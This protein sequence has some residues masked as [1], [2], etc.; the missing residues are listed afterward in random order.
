[1]SLVPNSKYLRHM[2]F[3]DTMKVPVEISSR[4]YEIDWLFCLLDRYLLE[5][6]LHKEWDHMVVWFISYKGK[7]IIENIG[8]NWKKNFS[9]IS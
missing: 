4:S 7:G 3:F 8:K 1:M 2:T 5:V 6:S 9:K